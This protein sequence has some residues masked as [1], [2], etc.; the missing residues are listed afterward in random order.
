MKKVGI[1]G[2]LGPESTVDYYQAII[3]KF[4]DRLGSKGILPELLINSVN[5]YK[6]FELISQGH[7]EELITYLSEAVQSL[8][9]AGVDFVVISG[10]TPHLV[11]DQVQQLVKV[12]MI[13]IVEETLRT[14]QEL[15]LNRLGLIGTMF[16][17]ESEFFIKPFSAKN[18]EVFVPNQVEQHF[19]HKK[20]VEEL[21]N[22][23]VNQET[24]RNF[25]EIIEQMVGRHQMQGIILGCTEL[26]MLI[27]EG[28]LNI[29]QLDTMRI[30][31]NKILEEIFL[32]H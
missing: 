20:I 14:A 24:K 7:T 17:M 9:R 25:L 31:V 5:M 11:F 28:D 29:P 19:I 22:G 12:P 8:E 13:S 3:S 10:N 15:G 32:N 30:H 18:I 16:T 21:E 1:I 6:V 23:V 26:P 27:K 4:Q 2:G